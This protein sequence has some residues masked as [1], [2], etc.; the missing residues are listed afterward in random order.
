ML[1]QGVGHSLSGYASRILK[2]DDDFV[3]DKAD[4]AFP[5]HPDSLPLISKQ[6]TPPVNPPKSPK[7]GAAGVEWYDR[8]NIDGRKTAQQASHRQAH[9]HAIQRLVSD[10]ANKTLTLALMMMGLPGAV[11]VKEEPWH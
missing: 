9:N 3:N 5:V 2:A 4:E 6:S 1:L 7:A 10:S 8:L 11:W